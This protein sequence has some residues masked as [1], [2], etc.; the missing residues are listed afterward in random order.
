MLYGCV[1]LIEIKSINQQYEDLYN[2]V[3]AYGFE[4]N[5]MFTNWEVY[6]LDIREKIPNNIL[7]MNMKYDE[8][9]KTQ[10]DR[11]ISKGAKNV[12]FAFVWDSKVNQW[13]VN[14]CHNNGFGICF[15]T[16]NNEEDCIQAVK[17]GTD[18]ITSSA[19]ANLTTIYS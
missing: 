4:D 15:W 9:Y 12:I 3:K 2:I 18:I 7:M 5:C 6:Y 19:I 13:L 16:I 17:M 1:P 8:D 11:F 10:I 14:Y